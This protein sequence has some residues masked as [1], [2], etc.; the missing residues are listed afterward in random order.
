MQLKHVR[1]VY[2]NALFDLSVILRGNNK[3]IDVTQRQAGSCSL[4]AAL[5]LQHTC[6]QT[7][8]LV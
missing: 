8:I 2:K 3:I 5:V 4:L 6:K 1:S 7:L